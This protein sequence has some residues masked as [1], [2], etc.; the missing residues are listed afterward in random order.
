MLRAIRLV[1][2]ALIACL[3]LAWGVVGLASRDPDG[4]AATLVHRVAVIAGMAPGG[5]IASRLQIGGPFSLTDMQ[6]KPVTDSS[7]PGRWKL[8]YFGYT[9]CPD[10]C[11]TELQTI[12]SA[13]D[14]LGPE[15]AKIVPLF[16]TIDPAR[17]TPT[18]LADYVKLF[19]PRLIGLTGTDQQIAQVAREYRVYYSRVTPKDSS[20]YLMDHSS[21]AYLMAPDGSLRSVFQPGVTPQAMA[22]AIKAQLAG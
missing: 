20:S 1:S 7:W 15:A 4:V 13:L 11:P 16:V 3:A 9:Y 5:V 12:S 21:F 22:D 17:D 8:V 14:A 19:D 10:V 6:G 18:V 2:I